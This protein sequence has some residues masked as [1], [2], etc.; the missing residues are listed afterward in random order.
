M[1]GPLVRPLQPSAARASAIRILGKRRR[2]GVATVEF[3]LIASVL[4]LMVFGI[5]EFSRAFMVVHILTDTAREGCRVA[6]VG[7]KSTSDI[8]STV[9]TLLSQRGISGHSTT[10]KVN[11]NVQDAFTAVTGDVIEVLISVPISAV[12]WLP[13]PQ[14]VN[15][16]LSGHWSL[17]VE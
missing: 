10:V 4:F 13:T 15:G 8:S 6:V 14:F 12:G 7:G 3:A 16:N 2:R 1:S 17:R 5:I 11:G 9:T